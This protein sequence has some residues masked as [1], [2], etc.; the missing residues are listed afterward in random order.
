[1]K[2]KAIAIP[3]NFDEYLEDYIEDI[4]DVLIH[5]GFE[6]ETALIMV[7]GKLQ[8]ANSAVDPSSTFIIAVLPNRDNIMWKEFYLRNKWG[9]Y[10]IEQLFKYVALFA[11]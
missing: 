6:K 1:M 2:G 7:D 10:S 5:E 4:F 9:V 8:L 11:L 3:D